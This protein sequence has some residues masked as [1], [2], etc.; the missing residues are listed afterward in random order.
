LTDFDGDDLISDSDLKQVIESLTGSNHLT[1]DEMQQLI[2]NVSQIYIIW[3]GRPIFGTFECI[4]KESS[5]I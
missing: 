3:V 5:S 2:D 4:S 1:E